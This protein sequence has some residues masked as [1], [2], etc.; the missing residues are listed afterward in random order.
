M[1]YV[2]F[3]DSNTWGYNAIDG[4]RIENRFTRILKNKFSDDEIVEEGLCG[5]TLC[6]DDPFDCD[7]NGYKQIS[8][9]I[10]THSPMDV[11]FIML[12]TNDAKRQFSSNTITLEKGIRHLLYRVFDPEIYKEG[13]KVPKV[14][15]VCPPRM[16]E[17]YVY[18]ERTVLNF[19]NVGFNMLENSYASL[20]KGCKD[21]DV[22]VIDTKVVASSFD[23]IHMDEK[24]HK[25]VA[26]YL[27]KYMR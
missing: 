23:G 12:G 19:G 11:L 21:F 4:S 13:I 14:Y 8:M 9:V 6:F 15:V 17:D 24:G 1:K 2:F 10:K 26:S 16:H 7:R 20:K 5:R 3:G 27:E 25:I 18:N 22:D